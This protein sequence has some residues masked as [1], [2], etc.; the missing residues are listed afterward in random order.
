MN[1]SGAYN[2]IVNEPNREKVAF[3]RLKKREIERL[4]T[5]R[6][7]MNAAFSLKYF[8][9]AYLKY[10]YASGPFA[11]FFLIVVLKGSILFTELQR[12]K[13]FM[14]KVIFIRLSLVILLSILSFLC[15][16]KSFQLPKGSTQN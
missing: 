8:L 9:D 11:F 14:V 2:N 7:K 4:G 15:I 3:W 5:N 16:N 12:H 1:L 6:L 13:K 10:T